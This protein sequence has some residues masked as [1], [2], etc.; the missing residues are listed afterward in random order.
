MTTIIFGIFEEGLVYAIMALG[1][2]IT[3][4]ILDFPDLSVDGTFPLGAALTAI[5]ITN[6]FLHPFAALILSFAAGAAAGCITGLIHVKLKVRDLLSGIIVMTALYSINLRIAGKSNLP[7]FSKDTIFSNSFLSEHVPAAMSPYVVTIILLVIV[8]V[9]KLLL[10]A[11]LKTRSGYLLR[12]VGDND[13]L[14]TSLAKDKGM[15]KIVGLAI[16]N[17]FAALAGSVYCQQKGF[18]DI[19]I[20]TGTIVIGLANVI[21]GTQLFKR[22]GFVKSTTAVI[23]GSIIYKACVSLALLLNDIKIG[24]L[25]I[26]IPVTASDLKL[27]TS[28]LFLIILVLST[29]RGKKVKSHA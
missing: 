16:A 1:V 4:K 10:D 24:S 7:I 8:L 27:I 22:F 29:S 17:G 11:Y 15:V 23:I 18:F 20:G 26:S 13:V 14:V 6:G 21:I 25:T 9:C 5:G 28:I 19:S 12:A 3:Y 2:Y